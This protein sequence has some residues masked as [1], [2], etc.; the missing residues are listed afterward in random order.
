MKRVEHECFAKRVCQFYIENNRDRLST[1]HH[2]ACEKNDRK[3]IYRIIDR[4]EERGGIEF[5]PI[6]GEPRKVRTHRKIEQVR[7]EIDKNPKVSDRK[8]AVKLGISTRTFGRIKQEL[9]IKSFVREKAPKYVKDQEERC[10]RGARAIYN[11][12]LRGKIVVMDDETYV[13]VD[14][15]EIPGRK[16]YKCKSRK[17]V[18]DEIRF[19]S[20]TKFPKKY[21]VWQAIDSD[22]NVSEPYIGEGTITASVYIEILKNYLIPFIDKYHSRNSVLFW[23][24]LAPAHYAKD[25]Q[26]FYRAENLNFVA[27]EINPPNLPQGRPIELFWAICKSRYSER[28][29]PAISIQSFKIIWRNL[30]KKVADESGQNLMISLKSKLR[31]ISREGVRAPLKQL[32]SRR[33]I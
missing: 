12:M 30:A 14:P 11:E 3:T 20:H 5:R 26:A 16:F 18:S 9:G 10:R 22:G 25:T 4:F 33:T 7:R 17:E 31:S 32:N 28:P 23:P 24:D 15:E 8:Q 1:F 19:E 13:P 27:R 6:P 2:F 29:Q 21:L